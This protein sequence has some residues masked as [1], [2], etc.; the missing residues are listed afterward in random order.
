MPATTTLIPILDLTRQYETLRHE[1]EAAL[2]AVAESGQYILGKNVTA[3]EQEVAQYLGVKH[4]IGC[5]NGTDA[6]FLAMKALQL[7]PGDEVITTPFTYVATSES[8]IHAGAKPVFVDVDP[9]TFNLDV[10]QIEAKITPK[11]KAILPV[12]LYG[13]PANMAALRQ[14]ADK[15]NL[16]IVEDCAQAIGAKF[17]GTC[18]GGLS[19]IGTFSFFPTKNLGA[20]GDGGMVTTNN[21]GLAD[22]L[23]MLRVHG[24]RQRYYHEE[25]GINSRLDD[26]QAAVLRIKLK[27]LTNWNSARQLAARRYN[28]LLAPLADQVITPS[29]PEGYTHVFHQYTIQFKTA[30]RDTVQKKLLEAGVQSM[31]Y[32]PVPQYKQQSHAFLNEQAADYPESEQLAG[33]VLSLPI[34]PEITEEEQ[35]RVAE[36]LKAALA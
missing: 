7:Q 1:V 16:F 22:R 34:F 4:A 2:C 13:L 29:I 11:T 27:H 10:T 23:R 6:I 19:D 14:I 26:M 31:I 30:D 20:M 17:N 33:Q 36:A 21:D 25:A 12:H 8:V 18:V 3:F 28:D 32:Y 24:S 15:H 9:V 35:I 5:A